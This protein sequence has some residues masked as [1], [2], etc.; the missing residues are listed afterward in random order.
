M[1]REGKEANLASSTQVA[2]SVRLLLHAWPV[3]QEGGL[4][5]ALLHIRQLRVLAGEIA[6]GTLDAVAVDLVAW[7]Q[8]VVV[9]R[10]RPIGDALVRPGPVAA[11]AK[12]RVENDGVGEVAG[13]KLL[14]PV[15]RDRSAGGQVSEDKSCPDLRLSPKVPA[16]VS[17]RLL[18]CE[19]KQTMKWEKLALGNY[20]RQ[21]QN[22]IRG[23][24]QRKQQG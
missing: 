20:H 8:G 4:V 19:N 15:A 11:E 6:K 18:M 16:L 3:V 9:E 24:G 1:R 10:E 23:Y 2:C 13:I 17:E 5:Q 14:G 7:S 12:D 22:Y 21:S